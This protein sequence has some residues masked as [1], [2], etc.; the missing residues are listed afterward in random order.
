[1]VIKQNF[2]FLISIL[3]NI[4][5]FSFSNL[6]PVKNIIFTNDINKLYSSR[7]IQ[8]N[9]ESKGY[10]ILFNDKINISLIPYNLFLDIYNFYAGS[11]DMGNFIKK[12][13]D[14]TQEII[15]NAYIDDDNFETTHFILENMGIRIPTKYFLIEKEHQTYR[16]RF[17][18]RENQEYIEFGKDLIDAMNIEFKDEKNFVIKNEEFLIKLDD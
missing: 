1:M 13:D 6:F 10:A 16:I 12:Y 15:I 9:L 3:L 8:W 2:I 4:Y 14:G 17:F 11:E 18:S 7:T 5:S